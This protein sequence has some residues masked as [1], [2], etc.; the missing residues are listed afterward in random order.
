MKRFLTGLALL[1]V[2][3]SA[4]AQ[5]PH[6]VVTYSNK[7]QFEH[8]RD[9]LKSA[10]EGKALVIDYQSRINTML[11]R[12][13]KEVEALLDGW[14]GERRPSLK[15]SPAGRRVHALDCDDNLLTAREG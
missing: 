11:E 8:V 14:R 3:S 10:I 1:V 15:R 13:G 5:A 4:F 6:P 7:A 2:V 12:T 9:D